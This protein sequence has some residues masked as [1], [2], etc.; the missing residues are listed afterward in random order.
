MVKLKSKKRSPSF[1]RQNKEEKF[2]SFI[3][4]IRAQFVNKTTCGKP[5]D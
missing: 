1:A 2:F 5:G 4:G 3:H